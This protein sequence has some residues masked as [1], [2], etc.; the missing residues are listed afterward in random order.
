MPETEF[1]QI[2]KAFS[3]REISEWRGYFVKFNKSRRRMERGHGKGRRQDP[4]EA[5]RH[6]V[7]VLTSIGAPTNVP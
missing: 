7:C 2:T 6:L 1:A 5:A 3:H 4:M